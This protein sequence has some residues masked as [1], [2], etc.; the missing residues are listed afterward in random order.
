MES[1]KGTAV[2][3]GLVSCLALFIL[4]ESSE[5]GPGDPE[6]MV[7]TTMSTNMIVP[8]VKGVIVTFAKVNPV[9]P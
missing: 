4:L 7:I 6:R 5:A 9:L 2:N 3:L 8:F 1:G